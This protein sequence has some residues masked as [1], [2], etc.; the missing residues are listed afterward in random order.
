M[1]VMPAEAPLH[2]VASV[3]IHIAHRRLRSR[4]HCEIHFHWRRSN[5][6]V[7]LDLIMALTMDLTSMYYVK[8]RHGV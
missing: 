5:A 2:I 8:L 6:D 4:Q 3:A 1:L 7:L